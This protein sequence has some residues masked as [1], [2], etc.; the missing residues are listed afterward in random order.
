AVEHPQPSGWPQQR[1]PEGER[2]DPLPGRR[3]WCLTGHVRAEGGEWPIL[4]GVVEKRPT[5]AERQLRRT[6]G[7]LDRLEKVQV[8]AEDCGKRTDQRIERRFERHV[9]PG[10]LR[11]GAAE[12]LPPVHRAVRE[13]PARRAPL[14]EQGDRAP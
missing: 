8:P 13:E 10:W 7:N 4:V 2:G 12:T 11:V 14:A 6:A 1:P 5:V 9:R 3:D